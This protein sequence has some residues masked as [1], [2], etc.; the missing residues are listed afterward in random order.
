MTKLRWNRRR[1]KRGVAMVE[2]GILAPIFAMMMMMTVYLGGVYEKKYLSVVK[3]RY[4]TWAYASNSGQSVPNASQGDPATASQDTGD[5][6]CNVGGAGAS[7]ASKSL[8]ICKGMDEE[9]WSYGPT[10]KFNGGAAK[11]VQTTGQ[12][13][14]NEAK[15]GFNVFAEIGSLAGQAVGAAKNGSS[16]CK[17]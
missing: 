6:P 10:L 15:N 8:F 5:D 3:A 17:D 11:K 16:P 1:R 12:V 14:C 2:A 4:Y 13:V 9:T 7:Q